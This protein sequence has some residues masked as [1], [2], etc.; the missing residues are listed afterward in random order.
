VRRQVHTGSA[1]TGTASFS[2]VRQTLLYN[3]DVTDHA[4]MTK[5][6]IH[7]PTGVGANPGI[8][9]NLC[10][11]DAAPLCKAGTVNGV[12]VA[13]AGRAHDGSVRLSRRLDAE[14][15]RLRQCAYDRVTRR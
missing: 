6:H 3:L 7:G 2:V 13:G 1:A 11:D 14:R 10:V 9:Q 4:N 8:V 5:V 15:E 12:L